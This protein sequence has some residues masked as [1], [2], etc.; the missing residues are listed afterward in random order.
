MFK[1][2]L[3]LV[4]KTILYFSLVILAFYNKPNTLSPEGTMGYI[5]LFFVL[6]LFPDYIFTLLF[7]WVGVKY[8][9][10]LGLTEKDRK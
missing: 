6:F 8:D 10:P 1:W 2:A 4:I 9:F 5:Y 3:I 7:P